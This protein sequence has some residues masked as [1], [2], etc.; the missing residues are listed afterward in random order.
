M[1]RREEDRLQAA[2]Y[3]RENAELRAALGVGEAEVLEPFYLGAGEHNRNFWFL[4]PSTQEKCVLRVNVD[5]QPFHNNQV[6]YE[7]AALEALAPSGRVPRPLYL[8]DT[9]AALGKGVLVETFCEGGQLDFDRL[10]PGDLLCA[11]RLMADVHA[12]PVADGCPLHR[13]RDP[14]RELFE[15]CVGRFE[16]YRASAFEDARVTRWA[17]TFVRR[18]QAMLDVVSCPEDR[19][20]IINTETLPSHFLISSSASR[21]EVLAHADAAG[22]SHPGYFIDWER[23]IIG[24]VAQDVA[25][26]TSPTTTFWDSNFLFPVDMVN[27]FVEDYWRAVDGRFERGSFDARFRAYRAMT[28]LRS[29]TWCCRA[30]IRYGADGGHKV[31]KT[32][33][34]LPVYLSDEFMERLLAECF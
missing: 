17:E 33:D 5:A 23:P 15:E 24:E 7:Y 32:A 13:P 9:Q 11:A 4:V 19:C 34:K 20:H 2:R 8:D 26:F 27:D 21:H 22:M 31:Q 30:L 1:E 28:A 14:L 29:V 12:V 3:L 16:A 25:Y 6:A 18:A 10:Q